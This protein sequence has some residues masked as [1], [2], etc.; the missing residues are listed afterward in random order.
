M[1]EASIKVYQTHD[2]NFETL[3]IKSFLEINTFY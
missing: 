1:L 3:D 2:W